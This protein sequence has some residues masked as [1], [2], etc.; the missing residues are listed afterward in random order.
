MYDVI[1]VWVFTF[2]TLTLWMIRNEQI[3]LQSRACTIIVLMTD[4]E[5]SFVD[6]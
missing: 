3:Y 6:I 5:H 1:S 2:Q 4:I